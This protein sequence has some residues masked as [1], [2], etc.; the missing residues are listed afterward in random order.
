MTDVG[1]EQ[2]LLSMAFWPN[3]ATSHRFYVYYTTKN[4]PQSPGC[5]EHVSG[6]TAD[7]SGDTASAASE[8]VLITI[9]HPSQSNH[10]GG[11]LSSARRAICTSRWGMGA[12]GTTPR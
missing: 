2:G 10:N 6:F 7:S 9:P 5:D 1:G 3:Y 8:R 12:A 11:R 4:C